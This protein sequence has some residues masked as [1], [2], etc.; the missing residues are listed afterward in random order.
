[1][2][3]IVYFS[4][5]C[6]DKLMDIEHPAEDIYS[7]CGIREIGLTFAELHRTTIFRS[8]IASTLSLFEESALEEKEEAD[9]YFININ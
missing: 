9:V 6:K 5:S 2:P 3:K 7:D 1:M 8:M 4:R